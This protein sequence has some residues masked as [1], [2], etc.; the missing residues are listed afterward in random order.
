MEK[1]NIEV[2]TG[3]GKEIE[4]S[5]AYDHLHCEKP[6]KETPKDIVIPGK[7]KDN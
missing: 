1:K 6:K 4:I 3:T 2:I 5:P 7:K